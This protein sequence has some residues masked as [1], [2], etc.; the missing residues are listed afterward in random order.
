MAATKTA[1]LLF[2]FRPADSV[3]GVSRK[4]LTRLAKYF[5]YTE[6]QVMHYALRKLA[7]EV[8]PAYERDDGPL[9]KKQLAAIRKLVPQNHGKP[10]I[11]SLF[12]E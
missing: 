7:S 4:T 3:A 6:T 9:T 10:M 11:E 2:R 1:S 5:G 8:L 12:E